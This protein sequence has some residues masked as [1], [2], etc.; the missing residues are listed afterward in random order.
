ME[1]QWVMFC[2]QLPSTPSSP[3]VTLWRKLRSAGAI[4]L[5]NG[6]WLLPWNEQSISLV[7]DLEVYVSSQGGT[8]R[9]FLADSQNMLSHGDI[10]EHFKQDREEEYS[11]LKEQCC[12]FLNEIEKEIGRKNFS[13]AELEENEQD[14]EK[15]EQWYQK[16]LKR[17]FLKVEQS[18]EAREWLEKCRATLQ[19][20]AEQVFNEEATDH[21]QKM[22]YDPGKPD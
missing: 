15:L 7:H 19:A 13:F 8:S 2:P 21:A 17:D 14:L 18:Q 12:D 3:R 9:V 5:D 20:F 11:E 1:Y 4:G 22:K 6:L 16:I 10:L